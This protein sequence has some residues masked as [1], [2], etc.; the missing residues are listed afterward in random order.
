MPPF[1]LA[2]LRTVWWTL[3]RWMRLGLGALPVPIAVAGAR[4]IPH[5][6]FDDQVHRAR[7]AVARAAIAQPVSST[8]QVTA[9]GP[10]KK[11]IATAVASGRRPGRSGGPLRSYI[12]TSH[13]AGTRAAEAR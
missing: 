12:I 2:P 9:N 4:V 3:H 5:D 1:R 7:C 8:L 11:S 6:Q 10:G 13:S